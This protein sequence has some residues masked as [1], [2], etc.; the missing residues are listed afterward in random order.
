MLGPITKILKEIV[1][2][3]YVGQ[4][5]SNDAVYYAVTRSKIALHVLFKYLQHPQIFKENK[6]HRLGLSDTSI[7]AFA[8][9]DFNEIF[10]GQTA[11]SIY[12]GSPTF[13]ELNPFPSS[14]QNPEDGVTLQNFPTLTPLSD[15]EDFIELFVPNRLGQVVQTEKKGSAGHLE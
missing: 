12:E 15:R 13:R 14:G 1:L 7:E 10:L 11:A 5:A 3:W 8:A 2:C 4:H 9:T 6:Y